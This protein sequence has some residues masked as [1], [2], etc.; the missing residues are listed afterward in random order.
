MAS[1]VIY[2]AV[3]LFFIY[4]LIFFLIFYQCRERERFSPSVCIYYLLPCYGEKEKKGSLIPFEYIICSLYFFI[5]WLLANTY[6][7][8][9]VLY[10]CS[11]LYKFIPKL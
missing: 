7:P 2:R 5:F 9:L 4:F 1:S 11:M 3:F 6:L 8:L 10:I